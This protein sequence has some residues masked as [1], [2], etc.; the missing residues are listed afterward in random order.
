MHFT[1]HGTGDVV[2]MAERGFLL[3]WDTDWGATKIPSRDVA[4]IGCSWVKLIDTLP[5]NR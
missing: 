2:Q 3:A 1:R 5:A 4:S